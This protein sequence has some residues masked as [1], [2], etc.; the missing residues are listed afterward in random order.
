MRNK[1]FE[2]IHKMFGRKTML[3]FSLLKKQTVGLQLYSG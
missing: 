2:K 3:E 1:H